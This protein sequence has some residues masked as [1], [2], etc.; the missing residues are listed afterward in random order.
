MIEYYVSMVEDGNHTYIHTNSPHT[1]STMAGNNDAN[2]PYDDCP[3]VVMNEFLKNIKSTPTPENAGIIMKLS[4][5]TL[6]AFDEK[7]DRKLILNLIALDKRKKNQLKEDYVPA[8]LFIRMGGIKVEI[9]N[10]NREILFP[11]FEVQL[12]EFVLTHLLRGTEFYDLYERPVIVGD[13]K[14]LE[15]EVIDD[16]DDD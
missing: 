7:D 14:E 8:Q 15:L 10:P 11:M 16:E 1:I 6:D 2:T 13:L 12:F 4:D 5:V 9:Y 3:S